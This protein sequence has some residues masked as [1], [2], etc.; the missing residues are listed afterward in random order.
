[1]KLS[2]ITI[3]IP[4]CILNITSIAKTEFNSNTNTA[5]EHIYK[6]KL[7]KVENLIESEIK[8][9][10]T[11]AFAYYLKSLNDIIKV[12][13][14]EDEKSYKS[15][16]SNINK[17]IKLIDKYSKQTA[18]CKFLKAQ[19][20]FYYGITE[21]KFEDY[22][23]AGMDIREAY[24]L[25][26]ENNKKYPEFLPNNTILGVVQSF[27]GTIPGTYKWIVSLFGINTSVTQG[28]LCL[29]KISD[30]K[31]DSD[32]EWYKFKL[33]AKIFEGGLY[34]FVLHDEKK[35]WEI[36]NKCTE[37]WKTNLF[38]SYLRSSFLIKIN[39]CDKAIEILENRPS[40]NEFI[41]L[42]FCNYLLGV[43]KL[44]RL[45]ND[46]NIYLNEFITNFKGRNYLKS[47]IQKLSWYYLIKGDYD[48]YKFYNSKISTIGYQFTDEDKQAQKKVNSKYIPNITLL[49]ARLL[50]DG[51]FFERAYNEL[52]HKSSKNFSQIHDKVEFN[53][54][55]GKIFQKTDNANSSIK[56]YKIAMSEG[57]NLPHYFAMAASIEI[58]SIFEHQGNLKDA[59]IYYRKALTFTKN[60]EYE[61]SLEQKAKAGIARIE[62]K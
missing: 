38:S 28:M 36:L 14:N 45:D 58:A 55:M 26:K 49:R 51:G 41:D 24:I 50:C 31:L 23:S 6:L 11:N 48:K 43:C 8:N 9:N 7:N 59:E 25:L 34:N 37:D 1:M 47:A 30:A 21:F 12:F 40:G 44:N 18:Y 15:L 32:N 52:E 2:K 39:N 17:N 62:K 56:Y 29:K 10:H 3:L 57:K 60:K 13:I 5:F 20:L 46:A 53:Y 54:R 35:A 4:L 22:F 19:L 61:A 33:E 42:K 27:G 16:Q